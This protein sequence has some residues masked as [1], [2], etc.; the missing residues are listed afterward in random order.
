[1]VPVNQLHPGGPTNLNLRRAR[2]RYANS[3]RHRLKDLVQPRN[4]FRFIG[5]IFYRAHA[6]DRNFLPIRRRRFITR[7]EVSEYPNR[8]AKATKFRIPRLVITR[9]ASI[10]S[11]GI[12]NEVSRRTQSI[13]R[14]NIIRL[15]YALWD[16]PYR[17]PVD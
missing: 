9:G 8:R 10:S 11:A 1:M 14:S 5:R 7:M 17:L 3:W 2:I 6:G 16:T 4:K 13:L 12:A 15:Y